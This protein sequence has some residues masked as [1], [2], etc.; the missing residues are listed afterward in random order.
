MLTQLLSS[1]QE[2]Q[3][4]VGSIFHRSTKWNDVL[5]MFLP[6]LK[7]NCVPKNGC[8]WK[9]TLHNSTGLLFFISKSKPPTSFSF[10]INLY[11]L[12]HVNF[13]FTSTSADTYFFSISSTSIMWFKMRYLS[14]KSSCDDA[15]SEGLALTWK[16]SKVSKNSFLCF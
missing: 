4:L 14:S 12:C 3:L 11:N 9:S 5:K 2:Y 13:H 7:L 8:V 6:S 16:L 15:V 1:D 10:P